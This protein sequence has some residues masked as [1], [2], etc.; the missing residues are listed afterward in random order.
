MKIATVSTA[1]LLLLL[2]S[3]PAAHAAEV[4]VVPG[5]GGTKLV[6]SEEIIHSNRRNV[7][8]FVRAHRPL[9]LRTRGTSGA[10]TVSVMAYLDG[11]LLGPAAE[12]RRVPTAIVSQLRFM[13]GREATTRYGST[14]G[15]GA[16]MVITGPP[17]A[18]PAQAAATP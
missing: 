13:D 5:P 9:W 2:L 11:N 15:N 17:N 4:T 1:A 16:I 8:D 6:T 12:L 14:H 10:G 18:L 3:T 7:Y